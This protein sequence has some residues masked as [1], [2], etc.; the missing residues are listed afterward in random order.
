MQ[1]TNGRRKA[2]FAFWD[3]RK[4]PTV[5]IVPPLH[6]NKTVTFSWDSALPK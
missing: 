5:V 1:K 4:T 2:P 6:G 3:Q